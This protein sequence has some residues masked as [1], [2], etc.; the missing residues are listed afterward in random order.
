[1]TVALR[2]SEFGVCG[3]NGVVHLGHRGIGRNLRPCLPA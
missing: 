1:M 3:P 2:N